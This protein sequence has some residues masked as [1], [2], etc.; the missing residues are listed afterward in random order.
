[1][2]QIFKSIKKDKISIHLPPL[3]DGEVF[4]ECSLCEKSFADVSVIV[5]HKEIPLCLTCHWAIEKVMRNYINDP[6]F[7]VGTRE[8]NVIRAF[9]VLEYQLIL[10]NIK[11][12]KNKKIF[13]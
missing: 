3:P 6:E 8:F 7:M 1:M 5:K 12:D 11:P 2:K 13:R 4:E 10:S 9:S